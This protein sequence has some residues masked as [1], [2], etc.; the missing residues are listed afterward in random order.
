MKFLKSNIR[1]KLTLWNAIVV[2]LIYS[3]A[4]AGIYFFMKDSLEELVNDKLEEGYDVVDGVLVNS[5]GDIMDIH[6][7]GHANPF[8]IFRK[9]KTVYHTKAWEKLGL[10]L[11]FDL[12]DFDPY[13]NL[14]LEGGRHYRLRAGVT[15]NYGCVIVFAQDY[16]DTWKSI[17]GLAAKLASGSQFVLILALL[18]GY[19]LAGRALR[20]VQEITRKA[21]QISA[22]SLSERLPVVNPDDEI[23]RLAVVFNQTLERLEYSF[24]Q[25]RRFTSDASHELRTPLTSL[26]SIGEVAL[27][28]RKNPAEYRDAIGSMLEETE[29]LTNLT[30]QLLILARGDSGRLKL[31]F[32]TVDIADFIKDIVGELSVLAEEKNISLSMNNAQPLSSEICP[33]TLRQALVNVLHNA[34]KYTP[35]GGTVEIITS[36]AEDN[37][38]CID[39]V[40]NGPG[41]PETERE[42]VFERF[43]RIDKARSG[44]D[45]GTGLGLSI[46]RRAVETN[47]GTIRFCEKDG[48][49]AI[50]RIS[51]PLIIP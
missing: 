19:F 10:P 34:V 26:R 45:G 42:K 22:D 46:A 32:K 18:G 8:L 14:V 50:C 40:D 23:G 37:L 39:T 17:D 28:G 51:I 44:A 6:H 11:S 9:G 13:L 5:G 15:I 3:I 4:A 29:R 7:L 30:D 43:Y 27:Q 47:R 49:G 48:P 33:E 12:H 38:L 31:E 1:L 35:P 24:K 16:T 20:P 2:M 25:L 41:I 21:M 36:I